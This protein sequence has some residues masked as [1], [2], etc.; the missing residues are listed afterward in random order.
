MRTVIGKFLAKLLPFFSLS[1][2]LGEVPSFLN[3][4]S[5]GELALDERKG[6]TPGCF[7]SRCS[8]VTR[9]IS[10]ILKRNKAF[11]SSRNLEK[12]FSED[13][14]DELTCRRPP[15]DIP[16]ETGDQFTRVVPRTPRL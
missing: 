14:L 7:S 1:F 10:L 6:L 4:P 5:S 8:Y 2:K 16:R 9:G 3:I 15:D 12:Q 13:Y 11:I